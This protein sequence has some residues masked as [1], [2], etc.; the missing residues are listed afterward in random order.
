[1]LPKL[2]C[3]FSCKTCGLTDVVVE[4][5]CRLPD[6]DLKHYVERTVGREVRHTHYIA[7]QGQCDN[8]DTFDVKLPLHPEYGLYVPPLPKEES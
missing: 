8:Q 4:V 5:R 1:M 7:S 6:E 2:T 3:F